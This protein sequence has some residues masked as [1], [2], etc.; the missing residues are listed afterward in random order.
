[1]TNEHYSEK[2]IKYKKGGTYNEKHLEAGRGLPP[3]PIQ[4]S[5]PLS[6][7]ARNSLKIRGASYSES[8]GS[9]FHQQLKRK[10][11]LSL[12]SGVKRM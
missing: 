9:S 12:D 1:V 11:L 5:Q 4:F 10:V 3:Q 6:P 7:A 8:F 2:K